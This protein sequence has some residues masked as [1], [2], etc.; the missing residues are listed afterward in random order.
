F[1]VCNTSEIQQS[2]SK[3]E[4]VGILV[5]I[6]ELKTIDCLHFAIWPV[7]IHEAQIGSE[8]RTAE[9]KKILRFES[10]NP[11]ATESGVYDAGGVFQVDLSEI[12]VRIDCAI[13]TVD[14]YIAVCCTCQIF[15]GKSTL[16]YV[17]T[18]VHQ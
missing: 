4:P 3:S 16:Q 13:K 1:L 14:I 11:H 12:F 7:L 15:Q 2:Q 9:C 6:I 8:T 5:I 17:G 18:V 10:R